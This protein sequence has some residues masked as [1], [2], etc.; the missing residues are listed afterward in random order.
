MK[1]KWKAIGWSALYMAILF[2]TQFVLVFSYMGALIFAG[3]GMGLDPQSKTMNDFIMKAAMLLEK[4]AG[5]IIVSGW[6][7]LIV[8]ACM[9]LWY[10]FRENKYDF[11]PNYKKAFTVKNIVAL[12]GLG[13]FGQYVINWIM[14]GVQLV[15]PS[16]MEKYEKLAENFDMSTAPPIIMIAI[17]CIVG[18]LTEEVVFRGMIYGKLRRAFSFWPAAIISSILFGVFHM[19]WVQGIY[20]TVVGLALAYIY[21]KTQTIWGCSLLHMFFNSCSYV[22]SFLHEQLAKL[23]ELPSSIIIIAMQLASVAI[24]IVLLRHF[25]TRRVIKNE[26]I[27]EIG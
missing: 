10:Y 19:N 15:A 11:R 27:C 22:T 25:R 23:G 14:M 9:G 17:V 6:V 1:N 5:L 20:A 21:E 8:L 2:G 24:V 13:F 4:G 16:L 18:P 3:L 26:N 7:D 12:V